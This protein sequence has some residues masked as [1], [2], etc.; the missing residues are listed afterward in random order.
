VG[1]VL[2]STSFP[3]TCTA[4]TSYTPLITFTMFM[5]LTNEPVKAT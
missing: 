1:T 4:C 3:C 5:V 2:V